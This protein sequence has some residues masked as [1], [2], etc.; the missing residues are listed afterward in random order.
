MSRMG[1]KPVKILDGVTVEIN[2][3]EVTCKGKAGE[4]VVVLHPKIKITKDEQNITL[5]RSGNDKLAKA[6]HGVSRKLIIN[7]I[8]GV[9]KPFEK[10]LDINGIGYR[11]SGTNKELLLTL[12]YS[13]PVKMKAPEGIDFK[14]VKNS[15]IISG[16]DKQLVG[17]IAAQIRS[18]RMPEPY[19]G[20]GIKYHDEIIKRKAGK[21]AKS[22][23]GEGK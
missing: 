13:H 7:A 4:M 22:A 20:K 5:A 21:A 3:Q 15:I 12:G 23:G 8:A 1:N 17:Q 19:K 2:R 16:V 18:L 10:R 6:I 11:V 9:D 14:I